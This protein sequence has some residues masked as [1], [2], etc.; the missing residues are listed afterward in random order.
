MSPHLQ[1]QAKQI[2]KSLFQIIRCIGF[3]IGPIIIIIYICIRIPGGDPSGI[4]VEVSRKPAVVIRISIGV[5]SL[6]WLNIFP[7]VS[8]VPP[9]PISLSKI[10]RKENHKDHHQNACQNDRFLYA[11][12]FEPPF[13]FLVLRTYQKPL[14]FRTP[15]LI[16][17]QIKTLYILIY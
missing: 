5:G 2:K 13:C 10:N 7:I 6:I 1:T 17:W 4:W 14:F 3:L 12:C 16:P 11:H 9:N 15:I 8:I